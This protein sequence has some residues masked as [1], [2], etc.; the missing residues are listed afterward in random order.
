MSCS[1]FSLL[2]TDRQLGSCRTLALVNNA[3]WDA[4]IF[5]GFFG[6]VCFVF[7]LFL[8]PQVRHRGGSQVRGRIG[9][10]AAGLRHGH[11]NS[12]SKLRL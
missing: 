9:A 12:G 7:L 1:L 4:H 3:A 6:L 10:T 11:S 2:P 5:Q 8:G